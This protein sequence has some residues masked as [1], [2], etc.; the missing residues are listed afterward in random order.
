MGLPTNSTKSGGFHEAHLPTEQYQAQKVPWL[1]GTH[2]DRRRQKRAAQTQGEGPQPAC[3]NSPYQEDLIGGSWPKEQRIRKSGDYRRVQGSGKKFRSGSFLVLYLRGLSD[4]SRIGLTVSRKIGNSVSRNRVKRILREAARKE[5]CGI[6]G[7]WDI[8]I[9][10]YRGIV[11]QDAET[12]RKQ[13]SSVFRQIS[14]QN[15]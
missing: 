15:Q 4:R 5:Y 12:I 10:P 1:S 3:A 9:I 11:G 6:A 14:S 8:V 13:L 7:C 2:E